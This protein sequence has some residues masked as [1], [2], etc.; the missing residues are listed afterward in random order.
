[1]GATGAQGAQGEIGPQGLQGPAGPQGETG[2]TGAQGSQGDPGPQGPQGPQGETGAQGP[3]GATGT[4]GAAGPQGPAGPQGASAATG[5]ASADDYAQIP[6]PFNT[7][8]KVCEIT[9]VPGGGLLQITGFVNY[10]L[11]GYTVGTIFVNSEIS[12]NNVTNNRINVYAREVTK[13]FAGVLFH[14]VIGYDRPPAGIPVTYS[15]DGT[16]FGS[17]PGL[18]SSGW[19]P[20][21]LTVLEFR[22]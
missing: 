1:M 4:Q 7:S 3:Q 19:N 5:F 20:C 9:I 17:S 8:A 16:D 14:K 15:V 21:S 18:K 22:P 11:P 2:A 12:R 10:W 6:I 13:A